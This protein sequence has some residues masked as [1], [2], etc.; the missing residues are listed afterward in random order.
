MIVFNGVLLSPNPVDASSYLYIEIDV[1]DKQMWFGYN[2]VGNGYNE[3][4]WEIFEGITK[5]FAFDLSGEENA[6]FD[7]SIWEVDSQ[8]WYVYT[9]KTWQD[10]STLT[11][12]DIKEG[13]Q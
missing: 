10:F 12:N 8:Y 13:G 7:E 1:V 6:R 2:E 11:W 5:V 3:G 9:G 4:K